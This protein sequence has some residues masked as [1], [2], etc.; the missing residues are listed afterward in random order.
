MSVTINILLPPPANNKGG[1]FNNNQ[2]IDYKEVSYT[3]NRGENSKGAV[4]KPKV[5]YLVITVPITNYQGHT[6]EEHQKLIQL[7]IN[8][9]VH[10]E[11]HHDWQPFSTASLPPHVKKQYK[12]Y[13]TGCILSDLPVLAAVQVGPANSAHHF[14]KITIVPSTWGKHDVSRFWEQL[15]RITAIDDFRSWVLEK[16]VVRRVDCAIDVLNVET[17]DLLLSKA[18]TKRKVMAYLSA[19][20]GVE[21]WYI[22]SNPE[23]KLKKGSKAY[24]YDKAKQLAA[25]GKV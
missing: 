6:A 22:A 7:A 11:Q 15:Q 12:H 18:N 17:G 4:L 19:D 14:M 10:S 8:D 9:N 13:K 21:T 23:A 24:L 1:K 2:T 25:T 16:G 5:D 3:Y 20:G